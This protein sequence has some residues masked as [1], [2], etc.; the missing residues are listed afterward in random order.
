M[1]TER[2]HTDPKIDLFLR[3]FGNLFPKFRATWADDQLQRF[4]YPMIIML[5]MEELQEVLNHFTFHYTAHRSRITMGPSP[6]EVRLQCRRARNVGRAN[7]G[8]DQPPPGELTEAPDFDQLKS[9]LKD[10]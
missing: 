7:T 10:V 3:Q 4:W 9:S 8:K 5:S 2:L 1:T 6:N